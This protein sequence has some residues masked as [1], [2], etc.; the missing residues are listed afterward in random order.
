MRNSSN[1]ATSLA[2][3][4]SGIITFTCLA[5]ALGGC[6][7]NGGGP[8]GGAPGQGSGGSTGGGSAGAGFGG[9]ISAAASEALPARIRRL[10]NAEY[11]AS[12]RALLGTTSSPSK[13]FSFPPDAKQGPANS[14]AGPA[15]TVN[16]AQ[17]VDPVL[18]VKL[19]TAAQALVAEASTNGKLHELSP[20]AD[21]SGAAGEACAK[22]F[23]QS[24]G[25]KA[26]RRSLTD[27]EIAV[28]LKA[29][30]V[31][32]DGYSYAEGIA[33][34]L[35]VLLQLPG[36]L[37][38]TEIGEPGAGTSFVMTSDEIA[39]ELSYLLTSGPPDDAL[40]QV[41]AAGSLATPEAR[42]SEARRLL[43]TPLGHE[44]FVRVV[45][46]WLGIDDVARREKSQNVYPEFA[47]LSQSMEKESR[48]FIE[49]VLY[50]GNGTLTDLLTADWT[51]ADAPLAAFYG[52][53]SAGDGQRTSLAGLNRRGILNQA[54]FLSVFAS[55]N[56]S[57]PVFRGVAIMRRIACLPI[58]DPGSLGI[59]VSF[60]ATD[61]S[62]TTR[63][64]FEDHAV[65][66]KCAGCHATIDNLGFAFEN[67]DGMGK[68][69]TTE[70]ENGK[71]I[72]AQVSLSTGTD[73]DGT[74]ASSAELLDALAHSKSVKQCLARQLFRSTAAR[75]DA[76]VKEAEDGFVE[77]WTQ[78]PEEQQDRLAE[79]LVAFVKSP[80][81]IQRRIP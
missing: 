21:E 44:R 45:R 53:T 62:K 72:D 24:V 59:V 31:G 51:V 2:H 49:E 60:P 7:A 10:S 33:Q 77:L 8:L 47:G 30:H 13:D 55:N 3:T 17:R 38:T 32:A 6:S 65:D 34:V 75:S 35:R 42:E 58:P 63:G 67:F 29:Y 5:L 79:V 37:Y 78:L 69:R 25:A 50:N 43:A 57:H 61:P 4:A 27:A 48:A 18:A 16:D 52:A 70:A 39:T 1:G 74:Y 64:R 15:F 19:D 22:A 76:S 81:F 23:M 71:P 73:L 36:F 28:L 12:V 11:D 68:W 20:C 41:A 56:G 9:G 46:E 80:A 26:Y 14:P 54:A 40:L 66:P